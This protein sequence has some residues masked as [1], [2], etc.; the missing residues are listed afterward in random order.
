MSASRRLQCECS[1]DRMNRECWKTKCW[2]WLAG[3]TD[4]S[5]YQWLRGDAIAGKPAPPGVCARPSSLHLSET[6]GLVVSNSLM[7][8]LLGV[9]HERAVADDGFINRFTA[10]QQHLGVVVG[11][12][13]DVLAVAL[14]QRQLPLACHFLAIDQHGATQDHQD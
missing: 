10:E 5:V 8:F 6:T 1:E 7:N 9:H 3:D 14:E 13:G 12:K 4:T 11:L 2:R